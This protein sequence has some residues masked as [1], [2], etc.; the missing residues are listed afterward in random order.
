MSVSTAVQVHYCRG[1]I[2]LVPALVGPSGKLAYISLSTPTLPASQTH[3][4]MRHTHTHT[5]FW[6]VSSLAFPMQARLDLFEWASKSLTGSLTD[7]FT[8]RKSSRIWSGRGASCR[9]RHDDLVLWISV[10]IIDRDPVFK[11][12][13]SWT[14]VYSGRSSKQRSNFI[15]TWSECTRD[16]KPNFQPPPPPAKVISV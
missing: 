4:H 6:W 12:R 3:T 15:W 1:L 2:D 11:I 13:L 10:W 7:E 5:H 16:P 9:I 14:P 8:A